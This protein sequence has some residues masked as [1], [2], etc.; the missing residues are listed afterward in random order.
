MVTMVSVTGKEMRVASFV[1]RTHCRQRPALDTATSI[2]HG[3]AVHRGLAHVASRAPTCV[4]A[5]V[6]HYMARQAAH[7]GG[8]PGVNGGVNPP[9][10]HQGLRR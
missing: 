7:S 10:C 5:H 2:R 1:A 3:L 9:Q 6:L 8:V 4:H